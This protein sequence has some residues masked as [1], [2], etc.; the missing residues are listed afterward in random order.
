MHWQPHLSQGVQ[1]NSFTNARSSSI[2]KSKFS[3]ILI[4]IEQ[5]APV[6]LG[7]FMLTAR[8]NDVSMLIIQ[9]DH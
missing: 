2:L 8:S 5:R 7:L 3:N 1:V 6:H 9:P 4:E